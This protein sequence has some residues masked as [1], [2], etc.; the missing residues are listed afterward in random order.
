MHFHPTARWAAAQ[1]LLVGR[2]KRAHL[3]GAAGAG[4]RALAEVLSRRGW[5]LTGSDLAA[6][7]GSGRNGPGQRGAGW[8][9]ALSALPPGRTGRNEPSRR[10]AEWFTCHAAENVDRSVELLIHS[11]AVPA[12]NPELT[13]AA[14]LGVPRL[15]Y[16]Q[17]VGGLS[18]GRDVLAVAGTHGK[19]T[20]AAMLAQV[21]VRAGEDPLV[22]CGAAPLG[23]TCGARAGAGRLAVVEACE[24]RANFL[25]LRPWQA[26]ILNIEPDHFDCFPTFEA[27]EAA[28]ARFAAL[29]PR[30]GRLLV[31]LDCP[32]ARHAARYTLARVETFG[33]SRAAD[34]SARALLGRRG[35]YEFEL[36]YRGRMLDRVRLR[37]PGRHNVLNALAAAALALGSGAQAG[38][39]SPALVARAL[40]GFAGLSRRLEL[41]GRLGGDGRE[42]TLV[43]DYAHLPAEITAGLRAL[44]ERFPGR[45]LWCLFQPHQASRTARLLD[46]LA[47]SLQN[48][49]QVLVAEIFRAREPPPARGEPTAADLAAR[50]RCRGREVPEMHQTGQ[51]IALLAKQLAPGDVLV[52]MGAGDIR[53]VHHGLADGLREDRPAG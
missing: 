46:E 8:A 30:G 21:L 17:A 25:H 45:R 18:A 47:E 15:S 19:S 50:L 29:L 23:E 28:F 42:I 49:D 20:T 24:Y 1:Q 34:W 48:A 22:L 26:V 32:A 4:M 44:R 9:R 40:S 52:T 11:D 53:K 51:L 5:Q 13:E 38:G 3:V 35:N 10:G 41:C 37:V 7:E 33:F 14:R 39:I 2:P 6:A 16:F 43:D 36:C 12:D 31:P 27:M